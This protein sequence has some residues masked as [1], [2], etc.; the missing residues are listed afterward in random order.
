MRINFFLDF[1]CDN[2]FQET[3]RILGPIISEHTIFCEKNGLREEVRAALTE[4]I[5]GLT[6][7]LIDQGKYGEKY[8][9]TLETYSSQNKDIP[10]HIEPALKKWLENLLLEAFKQKNFKNAS[11]GNSNPKNE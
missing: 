5:F 4:E 7:V 3:A 8:Y 11:F 2:N 6:F 9:Y 10:H 1:H